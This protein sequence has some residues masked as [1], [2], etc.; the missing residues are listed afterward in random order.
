MKSEIV[1][2]VEAREGRGKN[3]SRRLRAA[4][5]VPAVIYGAG[6][7]PLAVSVDP[8]SINKILH[9]HT[10]HNTIFNVDVA[11]SQTPVMIVDW[12]HDPIK[13]NLLHVDLQRIDMN[14]RMSVK[15]QVTTSGD[16]RGV[17]EQGGLLE[18]VARD[19]EIECLPGDIPDEFKV[20]VSQL[21][22]GQ[23]IRANELPL[24]GSM[25][26][27]SP[28]DTVIAHVVAMRAAAAETE[29]AAPA[30]AAVAEPEVIKKGK[31]EEEGGADE[32]KK[33]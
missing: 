7:D 24:S 9:S 21:L 23:N 25:K 13:E 12:Q 33:K 20:D 5:R 10:G 17:K 28:A 2:P 4:H 27:L 8:K 1:I 32:K 6:G 15:V 18:L 22:I 14:K 30:A 11:G 29:A 19:V 16:P 31:K 3:E 26:L